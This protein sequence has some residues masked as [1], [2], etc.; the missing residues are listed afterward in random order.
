M[1]IFRRRRVRLF[2]ADWRPSNWASNTAH[3]HVREASKSGL[4]LHNH[5]VV[6][7]RG[8][9]V[10][11][12]Q[13]QST[14]TDLLSEQ[15]PNSANYNQ[16]HSPS[17]PPCSTANWHLEVNCRPNYYSGTALAHF[18]SGNNDHYLPAD[19]LHQLKSVNDTWSG[20]VAYLSPGYIWTHTVHSPYAAAASLLA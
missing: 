17:G 6:I 5:G 18:C 7:G 9:T 14:I 4:V 16:Q 8:G 12:D 10:I 11:S 20:G 19:I 13:Y 15:C 3:G 1:S 2:T